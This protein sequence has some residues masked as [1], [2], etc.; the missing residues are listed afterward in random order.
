LATQRFRQNDAPWLAFLSSPVRH[1]R[2]AQGV[3][4][5]REAGEVAGIVAG[6]GGAVA[7]DGE[8]RVEVE[9]GADGFARFPV[10]EMVL[11]GLVA[12]V[13]ERQHDD[14]E[15]GRGFRSRRERLWARVA[16]NGKREDR[17][18]SAM[19]LSG[20]GPRSSVVRSIRPFT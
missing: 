5:P 20:M 9:P 19:F 3:E 15:P 6:W 13:Q 17:I 7:G 1:A 8:G 16:V 14:G 11:L 4:N 10:H 18:G 2:P 12:E